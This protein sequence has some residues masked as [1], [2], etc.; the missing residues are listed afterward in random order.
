MWWFSSAASLLDSP[1]AAPPAPILA[2]PLAAETLLD[3][4]DANLTTIVASEDMPRLSL[5]A[6]VNTDAA[7]RHNTATHLA[8]PATILPGDRLA[9]LLKTSAVEPSSCP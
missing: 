5:I 7:S 8:K 1:S 2:P 3:K 4:Q 9:S 6:D